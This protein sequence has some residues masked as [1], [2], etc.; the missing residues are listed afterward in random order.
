MGD[1]LKFIDD[2]Q[3]EDVKDNGPQVV[4]LKFSDSTIPIFKEE[5][6]K[7]YIKYGE[8]NLYP[9]YLTYLFNKSA[10]HNAILTG[11]ANYIF[12]NGYSG[13]DFIVNRNNESL[14]DIAKKLILDRCIFG[15]WRVELIWDFNG[16]ISEIY[17]AEYCNLRKS[18]DGGFWFKENWDP[19][20]RDEPILIPAFNPSERKG[21]QIYEYSDYRPGQ[22]Y[23]T[24]P[25]YIGANNYI[26]TDIEISKFH[27]SAI[28]NG[29]APS[30][31]IQFFTGEPTDEKKQ[32]VE[33][34]LKKKFVGSENAGKFFLVFNAANAQKSVEVTDLSAADLDKQ[35]DI[36]N[37]T[38]QQ[39]IFSGHLITSPML[40][41]IMEPGKLGGTTELK[42]AYE[43]FNNTYVKPKAK[44]F[45]REINWMLSFS[46]WP[47]E[48]ELENADPI[49]IQIDVKD[50]L[51]MLPKQ[52]IFEKLGIPEDQWNLPQ[53]DGTVAPVINEMDNANPH[54]KNLTGKQSQGMDRI[55]RK[56]QQGKLKVDAARLLLKKGWNLSDEDINVLLEIQGPVQLSLSVQD[57]IIGMFDSCGD[58]KSDY[59][60]LK[61]KKVHFSTIDEA[62][63]D[64]V[65]Y[66]DSFKTYDV[67][68]SENEIMSLLR[69][70][71]SIT[72]KEI[73]DRTKLTENYINSKIESLIKRGYIE[74][75]DAGL[76]KVPPS[77]K[78]LIKNIP[79]KPV[80]IFIKYS[81]EGPQD[82]RN[83]PFCAKMM[84]LDRLYNRQEIEKISQRLG[85]SVFDR[86]GG[87]WNQGNGIIS[88]HCRHNWKSNIVVKKGGANVN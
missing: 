9:E 4:V 18:K 27:L 78:D 71:P 7:D 84:Q 32:Q 56:Y 86:R 13:G 33:S 68:N 16:K 54:L 40:F 60:I 83:R 61:S 70:N 26:E 25:D 76:I 46:K 21:S 43:I 58:Y 79:N 1:E 12:G 31:M 8:N 72:A 36:L 17:H 55:I 2:I 75:T 50:V 41:G 62:K 39:E 10:K 15:S 59:E 23:Y 57:E 6:N 3:T 74:R 66:Y 28:R 73:S 42:T 5:K 49:G 45:N 20:K 30:K 63:E 81:Y 51:N 24:L 64:E 88:E 69:D 38:C 53:S 44:V 85:Y 47:G 82:S 22:K 37:K 67:S 19:G 29:M 87:F 35:F 34:R 14:N 80:Q 77:I 48:Y 11:K 52:F 65:I